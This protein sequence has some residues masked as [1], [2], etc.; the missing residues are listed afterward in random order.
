MHDGMMHMS[1]SGTLRFINIGYAAHQSD[2]TGVGNRST[3]ED[4]EEGAKKSQ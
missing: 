3:L 1:G 4:T 2:A